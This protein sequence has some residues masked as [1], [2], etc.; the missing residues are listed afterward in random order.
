MEIKGFTTR[1]MH[2]VPGHYFW[3]TAKKETLLPIYIE[4]PGGESSRPCDNY[5]SWIMVICYGVQ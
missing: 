3:K 4:A 1:E 2:L 5:L